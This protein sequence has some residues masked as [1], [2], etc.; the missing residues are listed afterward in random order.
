[1][2]DRDWKL[3]LGRMREGNV[4]P[5]IG[6]RLLVDADG[7]SLYAR[8]AQKVLAT[9]GQAV[10]DAPLPAFRE[11]NAAIT[12][13]K[14]RLPPAK[15]QELY[16]DVDDALTQVKAE[17]LATPTALKQLAQITDFKLMVTLTPDDLLARAL[18]DE[19][20]AINAVVHASKQS[21]AEASKIGDW[22]A[23]GSPV[24]LLYLFGK[25]AQSPMC[26]IHD[27]DVLE[28]AHNAIA[29]GGHSPDSFLA[30]LRERDLLLIGCNFPDW[31]SRFVLRATRKERLTKLGDS[32]PRQLLVERFAT[33]D[34]FVGFLRDYS[35]YTEVL[36]ELDPVQFVAELHRRW[37][38]QAP[39]NAATTAAG[40]APAAAPTGQPQS[41]LFFISYSRG[42]LASAQKLHQVLLDLGVRHHE[43]W[44]DQ[45][46]LKP[47]DEYKQRIFDGIANCKHFLPLVSRSTTERDEGFVF[48]EW[49]AATNRLPKLNRPPEQP[50]LVPVMLDAE[51]KP[52]LLGRPSSLVAWKERNI[53]FGH[54]P[55]GEPDETMRSFLRGLV[56]QIRLS[57]AG[58]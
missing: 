20:R 4:V 55:A 25:S 50:F 1:M 10:G 16:A 22:K 19:K 6:S 31:L 48:S 12:R 34:P 9:H 40:A 37:V 45:E 46:E 14:P 38:E 42:D 36:S 26:A 17:G 30:A 8:V 3:L 53:N 23:P 41:A 49:E 58:S 51:N 57:G 43:I 44:F 56:R 11:L 18:L 33:E 54:A 21:T 52:H 35:P 2:K 7:T 15:A 28:Y 24:Q 39:A 47:G 29:H 32:E 27:E 13:L 5:V